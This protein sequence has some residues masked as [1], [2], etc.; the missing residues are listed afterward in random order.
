MNKI[1]AVVIQLF[2]F[3]ACVSNSEEPKVEDLIEMKISEITPIVSSGG[4]SVITFNT[5]VDWSS[6]IVYSR[7]ENWC[8][9]VPES[10]PAG[11][12][13]VTITVS[14][15]TSFDE[16]NAVIL[17]MAGQA[18]KE[19][20]INQEQKN[21][22]LLKD[23]KCEIEPE[24]GVLNVEIA[25][26]VDVDCEVEDAATSW[27]NVLSF[28]RLSTSSYSFQIKSNGEKEER[29]GRICFY[30]D[31]CNLKEIFV[32]KQK[33]AQSSSIVDGSNEEYVE[34]NKGWDK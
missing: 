13:H 4:T 22:I 18:K 14:E 33:G 19:L 28:S 3:C 25:S 24:G 26:N 9:I 16:R 6:N 7:S 32:V 31:R 2:L 34:E 29:L 15:N 17:L 12:A 23:D 5:N 1:I 21:V 30:N 20:V 8:T 27:I 10:G 11:T